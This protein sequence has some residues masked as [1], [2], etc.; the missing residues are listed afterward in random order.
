M[1]TIYKTGFTLPQTNLSWGKQWAI[2]F[3][4][5]L[6]SFSLAQG[7]N[8]KL[9]PVVK[10]TKGGSKYVGNFGLTYT[11]GQPVTRHLANGGRQLTQGFQQPEEPQ[12]PATPIPQNACGDSVHT[13]IF[14]DLRAGLG[15]DKIEWSLYSN[16]DSSHII[17]N[18]DTIS[19]TI[20]VDVID[21]IWLRS[22][23]S[24]SERVSQ[25]VYTTVSVHNNIMPPTAP[26]AQ[27]ICSDTA[28]T[29]LFSDVTA[30]GCGVQMI[31]VSTDSSFSTYTTLANYGSF[32][33]SVGPDS[34]VTIWLRSR[35]ASLDT[36]SA[37]VSTTATVHSTLSSSSTITV[38]DT[39]VCMHDSISINISNSYS[40]LYYALTI[41]SIL[42]EGALGNDTNLVLS[43]SPFAPTILKLIVIDSI[44]GCSQE[45]DSNI[46]INVAS[47]LYLQPYFTSGSTLLCVGQ[48]D[49]YSAFMDSS[50]IVYY[51]IISGNAAIDSLSGCVT[52]VQDSFVIRASVFNHCDTVYGDLLVRV[53]PLL[54][55]NMPTP[56]YVCASGSKYFVLDSITTA[57]CGANSLQWS[58]D[59]TFA[60]FQTDTSPLFISIPI[61]TTI[62]RILWVRSMDTVTNVVS[63]SVSVDVPSYLRPFPPVAPA[64]QILCND[65]ATEFFFDS[66]LTVGCGGQIIEFSFDST[67]ASM[68]AHNSPADTSFWLSP[69]SSK[70]LW[71][72]SRDT[73]TDLVSDP[74]TAIAQ[75]KT[76]PSSATG[77]AS[78]TVCSDTA[79]TFSVVPIAGDGGNKIILAANSTF[80]DSQVVASGTELQF[81]VLPGKDTLLWFKSLDSISGLISKSAVMCKLSVRRYPQGVITPADTTVDE[82]DSLVLKVMTDSVCTFQWIGMNFS[83]DTALVVPYS[84]SVYYSVI[85]TTSSNCTSSTSSVARS[86]KTD[87]DD[88]APAASYSDLNEE[89]DIPHASLT[90]RAVGRIP[91]TL[92][93]NN[94]GGSLYTI[95]IEVPPGTNNMVPNL[96]L[97]YNSHSG[98]GICGWGWNIAGLSEISRVGNNMYIDGK[99]APV[100]F[101]DQDGFTLD[102]ERLIA[103]GS[104]ADN[105]NGSGTAYATESE[106]FSSIVAHDD[107]DIGNPTYWDVWTKDGLHLF[108]GH[109]S[110]SAVFNIEGTARLTWKLNRVVDNFGNDYSIEYI[111]QPVGFVPV[112]QNVVDEINYTGNSTNGLSPYN[113]IKFSYISR[114]DQNKK[115]VSGTPLPDGLL[116]DKITVT[117][118]D[119]VAFKTYQL[120]YGY[121]GVQSILNKIEET[122][123]DGYSQ[124]NSTLFKNG[125]IKDP[126]IVGYDFPASLESFSDD[127]NWNHQDITTGDYNGDGLTDFISINQE[128]DVTNP[129]AF[130]HLRKADNSGFDVRACFIVAG[131]TTGSGTV[132]RWD[133]GEAIYGHGI[134]E[135]SQLDVDGD[136]REDIMNTSYTVIQQ[137][138]AYIFRS[139]DFKD[140]GGNNASSCYQPNIQDKPSSYRITKPTFT[141]WD[142]YMGINGKGIYTGDFN[143]DGRSDVITTLTYSGPGGTTEMYLSFPA[144]GSHNNIIHHLPSGTTASSFKD[145]D[146]KIYAIDFDGDGK[147]DLARFSADGAHL[148]RFEYDDAI[149]QWTLIEVGSPSGYPTK[150]HI[151][152]WGDFNGDGKADVLTKT[153]F[154]GATDIWEM[155][156]STGTGFTHAVPFP[157]TAGKPTG[158]INVPPVEKKLMI[159]DF[160]GDGK[161]DVFYGH[162]D[163]GPNTQ[164]DV[165]YS[166]GVY[167]TCNTQFS[168]INL[169]YISM[170]NADFNGDGRTDILS[171]APTADNVEPHSYDILSFHKF[172]TEKQVEKIC[173][174]YNVVKKI[175]YALLTSGAPFYDNEQNTGDYPVNNIRPGAFCVASTFIPN[176]SDETPAETR[177]SFSGA[178]YH[179]AGR[180]FLGFHIIKA[181][182]LSTGVKEQTNWDLSTDY[183]IPLLSTKQKYYS[184][185][186]ASNTIYSSL[187]IPI[188]LSDKRYWVYTYQT[189]YEDKYH[190]NKVIND[191]YDAY[192]NLVEQRIA[193]GP[194]DITSSWIYGTLGAFGTP[195]PAKPISYVVEKVRDH[196]PAFNKTTNYDY[197]STGA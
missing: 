74:V 99:V 33:V 64:S 98:N 167:F 102:G 172:G 178:R 142:Y 6:F 69:P 111:N 107:G 160:N 193:N 7:Q 22:R 189:K 15:A 38:S 187:P 55:P 110:N 11:V 159:G 129:N 88:D 176:G 2:L 139:I 36:V 41:D 80:V 166:T 62:D 48:E 153:D 177:Y 73:I 148:Y 124:L 100:E 162:R 9:T 44:T 115:F 46:S 45:L 77:I 135:F 75:L 79:H 66:I 168:G 8:I 170:A 141:N 68:T 105:G 82:G 92:T 13:F 90:D 19:I 4:L 56:E 114:L 154:N 12:P 34:S 119:D 188:G 161:S 50:S 112:D 122:G 120:N 195:V 94:S 39:V 113:K 180:G 152:Y 40:S 93:V 17:S 123:T 10:A 147:T 158:V 174:G 78:Q 130:V 138:P 51:S 49:C 72:R 146:D 32:E 43:Y 23:V 5:L 151:I 76:A 59:S 20:G 192:G 30:L 144:L 183:Y 71:I 84:D 21:T 136:G 184:G 191:Q 18:G 121:N 133:Y 58:F 134:S 70:V 3:T 164:L 117:G 52:N 171:V 156:Y 169:G 28:Y 145:G 25:A 89:N 1:K 104:T 109:S 54:L 190:F 42:V 181:T 157:F 179:V 163:S 185:S 140:V 61:D 106:S 26:E 37:S 116:V 127:F 131:S 101:N 197:S 143:G 35:N 149:H 63:E 81:L 132:I 97:V 137:G 103:T 194:E 24:T 67:F 150:W 186:L 86:N 27:G 14:T 91:G 53:V 126:S 155:A 60:S 31:D 128:H 83:T 87:D 173:D 196:G 118:K 47:A 182:N 85:M 108:F 16:F 165:Y 29:F 95:P 175:S 57:G 65:T 125:D 96:S